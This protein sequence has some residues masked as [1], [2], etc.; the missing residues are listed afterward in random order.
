MNA[1]P[2]T[3]LAGAVTTNCE[4]AAAVTFTAPLVPVSKLLAVSVA[5]IVWLPAVFRVTV[6]VAEPLISLALAGKTAAGSL[7]L[8]WTVPV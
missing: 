5:V 6:N 2:A 4:A 7:L 1:L 3:A 8:N